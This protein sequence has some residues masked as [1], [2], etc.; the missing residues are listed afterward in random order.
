MNKYLR[1]LLTHESTECG[2]D[3]YN[4]E[5]PNPSAQSKNGSLEDVTDSAPSI[6]ELELVN[7]AIE[8]VRNEVEREQKKYEELLETTKEYGATEPP[9]L[10]PKAAGLA[11]VSN[12]N[13]FTSLEYNPSSYVSRSSTDYNPTP[14]PVAAANRSSKY[15]LGGSDGAKSK[16]S[17]LEYVPTVVTQKKY[18][19]S[20]SNRKYIIDD[21]KP[22]TDLEY[23]PLSNY[24]ARLLGKARGKEL[25]GTKRKR[26]ADREDSYSPPLKKPSDVASSPELVSKF[27]DSEDDQEAGGEAA[28]AGPAKCK[29]SSESKGD[30]QPVAEVNGT[31]RDHLPSRQMK[32]TAVQYDMGD[33]ESLHG[34]VVKDALGKELAKA[35]SN[36]NEKGKTKVV[37]KDRA[38]EK[39]AEG[40]KDKGQVAG[41]EK[42]GTKEHRRNGERS[43][44]KHDKPHV[45]GPLKQLDKPK[46]G[47]GAG[48][49]QETPGK[50]KNEGH[51]KPSSSE[52]ARSA[53]KDSKP[54]PVNVIGKKE[55]HGGKQGSGKTKPRDSQ[56]LKAKLADSH[57]HVSAKGQCQAKRRTLSH[58][59]LFGD[60][61]GDERSLAQPLPVV[62]P[63][64]SSDSD[65][66]DGFQPLPHYN[67]M[68]SL[69]CPKLSR[70][71]PSPTSSSSSS[72]EV[73]YSV[74]EH[75]LDFESDP[76]EEC[77]RIFNESTD[78]KTEDKGRLGKQPPREEE[79]DE[80]V[81]ED[82]LTTLF[83]GQKRRISH[84]TK[85]GSAEIPSKP[86]VRPYRPPTAQEVCYQR[87]RL[88]QQQVAQLSLRSSV[89]VS[90]VPPRSSL[91]LPKGEKKRIAHVPSSAALP[92]ATKCGK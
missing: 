84:V 83:P 76:M 86:V 5:L 82:S 32:E 80:K 90:T 13:S 53:K 91:V 31:Q 36:K 11:S 14:L 64:V 57:S 8:A 35:L 45:G 16:G 28:S 21:S 49:R 77:L 7:Q 30:R 63:D 33:I 87:I 41:K 72:D 71:P 38:K 15:T 81:P 24:S 44:K 61:S 75:D 37:T 18:S 1:C 92:V 52:K 67:E 73:A 34:T 85:Q 43:E 10:G 59:D 54:R 40:K 12:A 39:N 48:G 89:P 68:P 42:T 56:P 50:K 55:A 47:K 51:R 22:S 46:P 65:G 29:G 27:S 26:A 25:K 4:P 79:S 20:V 62:F 60:E 6:L 17:S 2:Y 3:P 74:L 88:A 78:V 19:R 58:A 69:K 23:D 70:A 66:D 9:S